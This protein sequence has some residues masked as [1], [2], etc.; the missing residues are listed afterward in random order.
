M[1]GT[2]GYSKSYARR[3]LGFWDDELQPFEDAGYYS[4][5]NAVASPSSVAVAQPATD[6]AKAY[7]EP[8]VQ[9]VR[10]VGVA[11]MAYQT[12]KDINE[13]NLERVRRGQSPLPQ[14]YVS[15]MQ[16]QMGVNVGLSPQTKNLLIFGGLGLA[17]VYLISQMGGARRH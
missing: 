15:A 10:D 1:A 8:L 4:Y 16:P 14:S 7:L 17:A 12:Q 3:G 6:W 2:Y 13:I 9:G 11:A 5:E